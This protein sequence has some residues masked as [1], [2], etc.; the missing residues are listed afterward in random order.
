M[1]AG[2][3]ILELVDESGV[4]TSPSGAEVGSEFGDLD[5]WQVERVV[6]PD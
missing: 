3:V 1:R 2:V 4:W 6:R 5:C